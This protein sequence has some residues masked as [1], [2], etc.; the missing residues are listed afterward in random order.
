LRADARCAI[1]TPTND[2]FLE[3]A[4]YDR[5]DNRNDRRDGGRGGG[6]GGGKRKRYRGKLHEASSPLLAQSLTAFEEDDDNERDYRNPRHRPEAPPGTRIKR[7]LL[8]IAED[9]NGRPPRDIK[10]NAVHVAKLTAENWEDE[11]VRETFTTVV[12][13]L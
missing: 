10:E 1:E 8:E 11:Y 2:I 5:R 12:M 7:N 13:K 4:D 9:V 3:M 6:G